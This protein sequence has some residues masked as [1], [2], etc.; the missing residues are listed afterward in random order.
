MQPLT[1]ARRRRRRIRLAVQ[2][3]LAFAVIGMA[4]V[5][6]LAGFALPWIVDNPARV[7]A[8]LSERLGQPV[9]FVTLSGQWRTVGP[10]LTLDGVEIGGG[11][12]VEPFR[13]DRAALAVDLYAWLKRGV[14]VTEFRLDGLEVEALR[15]ADGRWRIARLGRGRAGGNPQAVLDL[16]DVVLTNAR[17]RITDADSGAGVAFAQV[18][19]KLAAD[20]G[21]R[22]FGGSARVDA[23]SPPL[24]FACEQAAHARC[25]I[26]GRGL[27][28][29]R[30]LALLPVG[31]VAAVAGEVDLDAWIGYGTAVDTVAIDVVARELQLRGVDPLRFSD[32]DEIEP[33][34]QIPYWQIKLSGRRHGD[35]WQ[36]RV[37]DRRAPTTIEPVLAADLAVATDRSGRFAIADATADLAAIAPL[38]ALSNRLPPRLR[39]MLFESAPSGRVAINRLER[40]AEGGWRGAVEL[41]AVALAPG[42][43]S[44]GIGPLSGTVSID[45]DA[46]LY[47][48]GRELALELDWPYVF[49]GLVPITLADARLTAWRES[50]GWRVA[51]GQTR[52]GGR[53]YAGSGE[54]LLWFD[55]QGR[56]PTLDAW[57]RVDGGDV[58]A[59]GQ[60]WP[61]NAMPPATV[62]WLDRALTN[63]RVEGG[64]AVIRGDLDDWPFRDG[65]GRFRAQ[66]RVRDIDLD[67]H[68]SWPRARIGSADVEFS[69]IGLTA[70]SNDVSTMD[71]RV[72]VARARIEDFRDA[73]L[74]L[75]VEGSG[76]G[77]EL[78][79]FVRDSP[80]NAYANGYLAS[81]EIG[82]AAD[83]TFDLD[84]PLK[85]ELGP[86]KLAGSA[87]L[88]DA[89]LA[90][91]R[92]NLS[93]AGANGRL[94][95]STRGLAADDISARWNGDPAQL[96]LA[97]GEFVVD[98][99]NLLEGGV[100]GEFP[101]TTVMSGATAIAPWFDRLPGKSAWSM[102]VAVARAEATD[103]ALP[104]T[105]L[106]LRSD[107]VGTRLD[108]PAPLRKDAASRLP[109]ALTTRLPFAG[110][111]LDLVL[112]G[113]ARMSMRL[114]D[115]RTALS[116]DIA[117][118]AAAGRE[119]ATPGLAVRG[120][121]AALDVGG[122]MDFI[123]GAGGAGLPVDIDLEA[124]ELIALSRAFTDTRLRIDRVD[125]AP[126]VRF[127]GPA[128]EGVLRLP[129]ADD[130]LGIE[131]D[132]VRLHMPE[133]LP[134][135]SAEPVDPARLPALHISVDDLRLGS[136]A[137]GSAR[138]ETAP[139]AD[140]LRVEVMETRTDAL[141]VR[142]TGEWRL[143]PAGERS[144]FDVTFDADSL[145][146]MLDALGYAGIIDGGE[147]E[148]RLNGAWAGSPG[149]FALARV[150]GT[151]SAEVGPGRILEVDPGA[152]R[153][154]GLVSLQAIPR[155]LSLDFSDFFQRG[156]S[157]DSISGGFELRAG[158]AY[159][160]ALAVK[161]PSADIVVSGR[162]GLARRDYD[163][164]LLVTPRVGG[165]LPVVGALAAGP[166]GAAAGLVAQGVLQVPL[167]QMSRARY[168]VTGSWDE[169]RIDLIA[170]ERAPRTPQG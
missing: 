43:R 57:V 44:P 6:A 46:L 95:F 63:G 121:V 166:V 11:E 27:P 141:T 58:A 126:R 47:M 152:G 130:A 78:L 3:T 168:R 31:G 29:A 67:Y 9:R 116:T 106:S 169:P 129:R 114:P 20:G 165:V 160:A 142:G 110:Q 39:G 146:G 113:L 36:L 81:L 32:G 25:W 105:S 77:P 137:L 87:L 101:V 154:L 84:L 64:V 19:V 49:R 86:A 50:D 117:F 1:P 18:D 108:L 62:A 155:R 96:S 38:A 162:T 102:D 109:L 158:D 133:T 150:T 4:A 73:R 164:E 120:D 136:A 91:R 68:G 10:L 118:G 40:D 132:F 156:M 51:L 12:G 60:F 119:P 163:Q 48:A 54:A 26:G 74:E 145:G 128:M 55:P 28:L 15:E 93:F 123:G 53:G 24:R 151:L 100:R 92:W 135:R 71:N 143:T 104:R 37:E 52:L 98:P 17:V 82:G 144:A 140:G 76:N 147:C 79:A 2:A 33:R 138:I 127:D 103:P 56:R 61:A 13:V 59:S 88:R 125:G 99:A 35:A 66:A 72:S 149:Q 94:R 65:E 70:T 45:G 21:T 112:G 170:R 153:L 8:L 30:W 148:V 34:T 159:T 115:A 124:G 22:R 16:A 157:F 7:Q 111:R 69:A 122:W 75:R 85:R 42:S 14:S 97:I 139:L 83:V 5:V 41:G 167:N 134:G 161:G 131:A 80:I 107:L 90:D 23:D 89:D